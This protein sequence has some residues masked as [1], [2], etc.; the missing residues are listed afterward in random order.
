MTVVQASDGSNR[1]DNRVKD[2]CRWAELRSTGTDHG[3]FEELVERLTKGLS[4]S[5]RYTLV[6][7]FTYIV[8]PNTRCR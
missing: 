5:Y 6:C 4:V 8:H 7:L 3:Y 2:A 1:F